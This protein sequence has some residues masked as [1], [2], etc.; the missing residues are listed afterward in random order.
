VKKNRYVDSVSL[1]GVSERVTAMQGIENAEAQMATCANQDV[2]KQLGYEL[3]EIVSPNDLVIAITADDE[4]SYN[5]ALK[6]AEDII[7]RKNVDNDK[8]Y[9][10]ISE[11]DPQ[12]DRYDL[13]VFV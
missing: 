3:P 5:A 13:P 7:D 6:L 9:S 2:L 1:L 10:D 12:E 8:H 11:I 4:G